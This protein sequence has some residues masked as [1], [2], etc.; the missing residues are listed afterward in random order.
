MWQ[1][2]IIGVAALLGG[3][4]LLVAWCSLVVGAR[5]DEAAD[6]LWAALEKPEG[7]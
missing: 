5:A 7:K 6:R 3:F 2:V 4:L 1:W